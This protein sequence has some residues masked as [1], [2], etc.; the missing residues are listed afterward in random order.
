MIGDGTAPWGSG[1][2]Y[3]NSLDRAL[4]VDCK[5]TARRISF[6]FGAA[7]NP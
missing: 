6:Y 7:A 3:Q 1:S 2:F 5:S 4:A